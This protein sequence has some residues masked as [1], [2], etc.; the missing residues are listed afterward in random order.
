MRRSIVRLAAV[1][2]VLASCSARTPA[3]S[4]TG[5]PTPTASPSA[6]VGSSKAVHVPS[7]RYAVYVYKG[8]IW[9]YDARA[10]TAR[11][12]A[13]G[14]DL[15]LPRWIDANNVSFV[16][17]NGDASTLERIDLKSL[18]V[19]EIFTADT[20]I[21]AYGWSPDR[22]TIAYVTTDSDAYPHIRF[23]SVSDG[24]TQSVATLARALGRE[25]LPSDQMRIEYS[26]TGDN[27]L[28]V[29]TPADG[30]PGQNVPQE[31]S[32]FQIRSSAGVLAFAG[33][34]S[35]EPTMGV[36][37][38][39]GTK[40]VYHDSSGVRA[41]AASSNSTRGL[42]RMSWFD[43]WPS[44]DSRFIAFDTGWQSASV[45][46]RILD[47]NSL[48]LKT[49]SRSGR[50]FPVFA[51][52]NTIWAQ[53]VKACSDSCETPVEF[54]DHVY[55]IDSRT[56]SERALALKSLQDVDVLYR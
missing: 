29:Y 15:R 42:R 22:Q 18:E 45:R 44:R 21:Q 13:R 7:A 14:G 30:S 35:R 8:S 33:P 2:A 34:M 17:N 16:Q 38:P 43:P 1:A 46:V 3:P 51:G 40:V 10:N 36:W 32:Q 47:L 48:T 56:G 49:V 9:L 23:R 55:A 5:S 26:R 50:A 52:P 25:A 28:I 31:Q 19:S 27:V 24:A 37:T 39:N 41:W 54:G 20:G 12:L 6:S 11:E 4:A 53:E